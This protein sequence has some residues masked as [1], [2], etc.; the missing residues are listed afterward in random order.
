MTYGLPGGTRIAY[1][2]KGFPDW[3]YQLGECFGVKASTYP[4]HQESSRNEAGF[5]PNPSRL[6]RGIDWAGSVDDME[7]F[8]RYLLTIKDDLEQVI[9]ANP[10]TGGRVGVAG[11]RDV[12]ASQY[13]SAAWAGHQDHVHTR[14][15]K[16]IPLPEASTGQEASMG[17][18]GDP[19][20]LADVLRAEGLRCD[21][22]P[23]AF[24]RGH[25][26]MADIWGVLAHHTG[27]NNATW[28]SIAHHPT[29]GL[30][31]Q[32]HLSRDGVYTL[33]GVGIAWHAGK[34]SYPGVGTNNGNQRLIGIEAANDGGGAPGKPHRSSWPD[35]QY[36]A[37]VRGVAAILR[38]LGYGAD[39]CIAHKEWAGKSQGKWDPGAIDMS[40]FRADIAE[41]LKPTAKDIFMALS[42]QQQNDLYN[43]VMG[44]ASVAAD[45][46]TQLRG[47]G[48]QGWPQLGRNAEGKHLTVVDALAAIKA[49]D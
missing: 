18:T 39:R 21:I 40:T 23:G 15:S 43:A 16:P 33:C 17:W 4:G 36:D 47:P 3:V 19:V 26:D 8:A 31:S 9:W 34:G 25:G 29:L 41:H 27:S 20:W 7:R 38:K 32:L 5:A 46:Q 24:N 35:K 6:N 48:L 37:Y 28:Q 2:S 49:A 1:G 30:A 12:T 42:D 45:I 44:I 10:R 14:Q 22:A 11:G 13:Y